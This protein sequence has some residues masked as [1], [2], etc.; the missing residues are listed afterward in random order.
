MQP[1]GNDWIRAKTLK[2]KRDRQRVPYKIEAVSPFIPPTSK[3][4]SLLKE[5]PVWDTHTGIAQQL[6][7]EN[8]EFEIVSALGIPT[9]E[10]ILNSPD[11]LLEPVALTKAHLHVTVGEQEYLANDLYSI[12]TRLSLDVQQFLANIKGLQSTTYATFIKELISLL[13]IYFLR[14]RIHIPV[15][16]PKRH[17]PRLDFYASVAILDAQG[18]AHLA[19][20]NYFK[21][22][23]VSPDYRSQFEV[24]D[25]NE[26]FLDFL[27][28]YPLD[29]NTALWQPEVVASSERRKVT[30][31][32]MFA[33]AC[34]LAHPKRNYNFEQMKDMT[35]L[36][37]GRILRDEDNLRELARVFQDLLATPNMEYLRS[38]GFLTPKYE[39]RFTD[40]IS[41]FLFAIANEHMKLLR[42]K[43]PRSKPDFMNFY[44]HQ[45]FDLRQQVSWNMTTGLQFQKFDQRPT[46]HPRALE[47]LL[48]YYTNLTLTILELRGPMLTDPGMHDFLGAILNNLKSAYKQIEGDEQLVTANPS[49]CKRIQSNL[50]MLTEIIT[51]FSKQRDKY[52]LPHGFDVDKDFDFRPP[53]VR[54]LQKTGTPAELQNRPLDSNPSQQSLEKGSATIDQASNTLGPGGVIEIK[55]L[56]DARLG[57]RIAWDKDDALKSLQSCVLYLLRR[58]QWREEKIEAKLLVKALQVYNDSNGDIFPSKAEMSLISHQALGKDIFAEKEDE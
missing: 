26:V 56:K 2:L 46:Y 8:P 30:P 16:V 5:S 13:P 44:E 7:I 50:H 47:Q 38:I 29:D 6:K 12:R 1:G 32:V 33:I 34:L 25:K 27:K 58:N 49:L 37:P 9:A 31:E 4:E 22:G 14:S 41:L 18:E 42:Q 52:L 28:R 40:N 45:L 21:V 51:G 15:L 48:E 20:P 19:A 23:Q 39:K 36:I 57:S 11:V 43:Y 35:T 10:E 24:F 17:L 3:I 55:R 54:I 53:A